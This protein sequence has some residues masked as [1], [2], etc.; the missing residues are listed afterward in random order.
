MIWR[1]MKGPLN[2]GEHVIV[3][4]IHA[5]CHGNRIAHSGVS[6]RTPADSR[7]GSIRQRY[8]EE[9]VCSARFAPDPCESTRGETAGFAGTLRL[10]STQRRSARNTMAKLRRSAVVT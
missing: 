2:R 10:S 9:K 1:R 3:F 6:E 7:M 4:R 5:G 8:F